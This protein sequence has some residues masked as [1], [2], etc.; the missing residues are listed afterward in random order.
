MPLLEPILS[1]SAPQPI[2][3]Y[4]QAI[5]V[6]PLLFCSGQIPLDPD[7][8]EMRNANIEE[9]TTWVLKNL[10]SVLEAGGATWANVAKTTIFL[11]DLADFATVNKLYEAAIGTARPARST[12]QVS[13]LPRAA[14]VEIECI[15][16]LG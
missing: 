16:Y 9:E 11:T 8:N 13:Q 4:S 10:R 12:V 5:R 2:G 6:G 15:A 14:R 7:S 3:P 1:T